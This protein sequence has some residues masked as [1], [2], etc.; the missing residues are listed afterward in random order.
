MDE[1]QVIKESFFANHPNWTAIDLRSKKDGKWLTFYNAKT[2]KKY[3]GPRY[4]QLKTARRQL[5]VHKKYEEKKE[6]A[7][8]TIYDIKINDNYTSLPCR[9]LCP[10]LLKQNDPRESPAIDLPDLSE[11]SYKKFKGHPPLTTRHR[12]STHLF[13]RLR[14]EEIIQNLPK[15]NP[16]PPVKRELPKTPSLFERSI[17]GDPYEYKWNDDTIKMAREISTAINPRRKFKSP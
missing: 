11:Y 2:N 4:K 9:P 14:Q 6:P 16:H 13:N 15:F 17:Q 1:I 5:Y 10:Y 7:P 3:N 12:Y 8:P